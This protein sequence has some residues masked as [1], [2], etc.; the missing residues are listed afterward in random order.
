MRVITLRRVH[1]AAALALALLPLLSL[2]SRALRA[3]EDDEP[4]A[5]R[6]DTVNG[7][8]V[9]QLRFR[10]VGPQ[11]NRVSAVIGEPGNPNVYYAGAASG[12]IW[13]STDGGTNWFPIA[14]SLHVSSIGSL[15]IAPSDHSIIW[16]G[17]GEPFIRSNI[18]IGDGVYRSLDGGRTWKH[19]GLE[20]TGRIAR[21]IV[22]PHDPNTVFACALGHA[23]G[24]QPE[25]G[26]YRTT[27]GGEHWERVLF[28]NDS[29]GCSDLSMDASS[30][31]VLLA[32]TWQF[33]I[34][35][36]GKY[37]GGKG[38]GVWLS[39]DGGTTW[40]RIVG[41]GL[42]T[43]PVGKVAVAIA[44]NDPDRMY[45]L[46]ET[47]GKGSLWRSDD[48]G[49][50]WK[51]VSY[52]HMLAER[53]HY[54]TRMLVSPSNENEVYF[55]SNTMMVTRDGGETTEP[56]RWGG[57]NHDMWADPT[58][59]DRMMIGFDGGLMITTNHGRGWRDVILPIAQMYHVAV[60]DRV[61][62]WVYGNEQDYYSVRGPS[63]SLQGRSIPSTLWQ[64]TAGCETGFSVPDPVDTNVV[65]GSC[66]AGGV[67][68]FD[69]RTGHEHSVDPWPD[70][71]LD[72][73]A[74]S[75]KY[76]WNWTMPLALSPHDHNTVYVGS[77]YVHRTR[78]GGAHWEV[79]SP[80]LTTNDTTKLGPSGGLTPDNLG[81]EYFSTLF[82]I[83]ESPAAKGVIWAGSNDGLVHVTRDDGAHW[84]NV[85]PPA[86][87]LPKWGTI[88]NVEPSR[89]DAGTAYISVDFHQ[90][91]DRDPYIYRTSDYG[92]TWHRITDGIPR[93]PFSYVH[94][95]RED[96]KR[97][98]MLYAGTENGL[99]V[100][101]DD[102]GHW[103]AL[104]TN[105]PHAPVSWLAIQ[106]RF[107][108]L[109]VA[110]SG[111]GV[112]ILDD[113]APVRELD[114]LAKEEAHLFAP[115]PAYRFI[116]VNRMKTDP[117]D[118][119][120]GRNPPYGAII[121][122][123]VRHGRDTTTAAPRDTAA[124][125]GSAPRA[126]GAGSGGSADSSRASRD[127]V[128]IVIR[129]AQGRTVRKLKGPERSGIDRVAWDLRWEKTKEVELRTTPP[130]QTHIW[131]EKRFV[132]KRTRP[133]VHY[134]IEEPKLGPLAAPG[135]YTVDIAVRGT[136]YTRQLT[137]LRDPRSAGSDDDVQAA[138]R[139][140]L[141]VHDEID[142]T[143]AAI[144]HIERVR[145]QLEDLRDMYGKDSTMKPLLAQAKSV[146]G[147]LSAVE[148]QLLQRVL[149]EDDPKTY[150]AP[151]QLYVKLLFLEGMV[152]SGAGD[153]AGNPD[154]PPTAA[155]VEVNDALKRRLADALAALR[156]VM[157]RDLP[158]LNRAVAERAVPVVG[159]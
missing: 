134:G 2:S 18:S 107:D 155:E 83:A 148:D 157:E 136:H 59:P 132:G 91:N 37:S 46:M 22:D 11:G 17:T 100:S 7:I 1:A 104:Q 154:F 31:H 156:T 60:D 114:R 117:N 144:N 56:L 135:T 50:L 8:D 159:R 130:G 41:H 87:L 120:A 145:K 72:A 110:T 113:L 101:Y 95:V 43:T 77:Q 108:D 143:V 115:R 90:V 131:E 67:A 69:L 73:P 138:A 124:R 118:Q 96:P 64:T 62:Y 152:G 47:G 10:F 129:D 137:V 79:I 123:Y 151:M 86:K 40:K 102:G 116:Q 26:V 105:L 70:K 34:H 97:R 125:G 61:P 38:S 75:I 27:D 141:E 68:R 84:T 24:P 52:S 81:V 111:R 29:T 98:G 112:W 147:K 28:V 21:V 53:P 150:R 76:R 44:P 122:Y 82:A 16:A 65:W 71:S 30:A 25:R 36:W 23:Y 121:T 35:T 48:G 58:N 94:V 89:W 119:S 13:K 139:F 15:A 5:S 57:D 109:V 85:T 6:G 153:V 88:S 49:A 32:G 33:E 142:T 12:G 66:Y 106:E 74:D 127:S 9:S 128:E 19:M 99:Y 3:Q 93:S 146:D 149:Q 126:G 45:V 55:P 42:P 158:A 80:D 63:N 14:D 4:S 103:Q 20:K 133:V 92:H 78:D 39:R 140:A 51:T 54:Y